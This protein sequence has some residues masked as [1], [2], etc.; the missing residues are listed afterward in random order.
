MEQRLRADPVFHAKVK[1]Q[2]AKLAAQKATEDA[3]I[4]RKKLT[5][6][7]N[8]SRAKP[9]KRKQ[10]DNVTN[11]ADNKANLR[12]FASSKVTKEAL[13]AVHDLVGEWFDFTIDQMET[14]CHDEGKPTIDTWEDCMKLLK[15]QGIVKDYWEYSGLC[16]ELLLNDESAKLLPFDLPPGYEESKREAKRKNKLRSPS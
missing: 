5:Q 3:T 10:T 2:R 9:M 1:S 6:T 13:D 12:F 7:T 16:H 15:R 14:F 8:K 11:P 4:A